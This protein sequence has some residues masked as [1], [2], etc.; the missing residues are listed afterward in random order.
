MSCMYKSALTF[1]LLA[2]SFVM[3]V[4]VPFMNQQQNSF[5]NVMAQEHDKYGDSYYSQYSTDDKKYECRTVGLVHLR[6][7][8]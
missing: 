2:S 6:A 5:S 1:G 7:S 4:V 3:L 8:L